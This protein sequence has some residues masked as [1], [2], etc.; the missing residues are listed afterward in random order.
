MSCFISVSL[1]WVF[2][3]NTDDIVKDFTLSPSVTDMIFRDT[4]VT[5]Y[6]LFHFLEDTLYTVAVSPVKIK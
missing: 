3:C 6:G 1:V 5:S 2:I 4:P